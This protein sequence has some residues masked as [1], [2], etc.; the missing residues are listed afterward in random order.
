MLI[1]VPY[2]QTFGFDHF[3][4]FMGTQVARA[5]NLGLRSQRLP[6]QLLAWVGCMVNGVHYR[7]PAVVANMASGLDI[8]SGG[9]FELGLG[10]GWNEEESGAY[11]IPLGS[12]TERFDRFD[13]ALAVIVYFFSKEKT[14]FHG[15]Y[16]SLS[17]A[18][19]NPKVLKINCLSASVERE[20]EGRSLMW[21]NMLLTGIFRLTKKLSLPTNL[22]PLGFIVMKLR[23]ISMRSRFLPIFC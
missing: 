11:G 3:I 5:L 13:E 23:G 16:F 21:L 14:S 15:K 1:R 4:L 12:L 22:I 9:R 17:E 10:A 8:I 19:N 18:L 2:I 6:K 20:K 7:H